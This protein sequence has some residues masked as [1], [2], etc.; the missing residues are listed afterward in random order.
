MWKTLAPVALCALPALA[1]MGASSVDDSASRARNAG[2]CRTPQEFIEK[3]THVE[4]QGKLVKISGLGRPGPLR[5]VYQVT[6]QG[7]TYELELGDLAAAADKLVERFVRIKGRLEQR[8]RD[9][10]CH[11]ERCRA[12]FPIPYWIVIV[13]ELPTPVEFVHQQTVSGV[14]R[15]D[16]Q[17]QLQPRI[18]DDTW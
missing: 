2:G 17:G 14:V 18:R 8:W 3:T 11:D 16:I 5:T 7:Q 12:C 1:A 13:T 9:P 15:A 6:V 4:I 10:C